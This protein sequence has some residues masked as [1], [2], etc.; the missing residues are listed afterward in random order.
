MAS[1]GM[2]LAFAVAIIA[3]ALWA[4]WVVR[5][6]RGGA[7]VRLV[8]VV[9]LAAVVVFEVLAA[10][11]VLG[12]AGDV[13][14][15]EG[16]NKVSVLAAG[17]SHGMRYVAYAWGSVIAAVVVLALASL[18]APRDSDAPSARVVREPRRDR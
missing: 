9:T 3:I 8:P 1:P 13:G 14:R 15:A 7:R 17:I 2:L 4:G 10:R 5:S 6:K 16:A 11:T 12:T 18:R